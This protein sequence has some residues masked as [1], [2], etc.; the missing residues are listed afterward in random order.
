MRLIPDAYYQDVYKIDFNK[1]YKKGFR[2]IFFDVDNTLIPYTENKIRKENKKLIDE[3]K[4]IGLTP[5]IISNSHSNRIDSII[6]DLEI[7]GF[8]FSKKPLKL[9]YKKILR[10]YEKDKCIFIGDQLMTDVLGAKRNDF[11]V[12][13]VDRILNIEP[14]YTKFWRFFENKKLKKYKKSNFFEIGKY[15]DNL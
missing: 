7:E 6:K 13:L 14:I 8:T 3:I 15:Y 12:I 2:F 5:I 1:I 4:K 9:T 11:K 10:K